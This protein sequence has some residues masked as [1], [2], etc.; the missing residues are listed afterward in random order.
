MGKNGM[1]RAAALAL[2]AVLPLGLCAC[3]SEAASQTATVLNGAGIAPYSLSQG[4]KDVLEAFGMFGRSKLI[5]FCGPEGASG[6]TVHVYR[7]GMDGTWEETGGGSIGLGQGGISQGQSGEAG[8]AGNVSEGAL[9]G[10]FALELGKDYTVSFRINSQ[11]TASYETEPIFLEKEIVGSA[12]GFLEEFREMELDEEAP[13]AVMAYDSGTRM[14]SFSTED[15]FEPSKFEGIDLVQAVTLEFTSGETAG[16]QPAPAAAG[17]TVMREADAGTLEGMALYESSAFFW[18]EEEW[19]LQLWAQEDMVIDGELA[20]DD[21]CRFV[22]RAVQGDGAYTLF[23]DR[24]QLGIPAGEAWMD[25]E[26][27]LHIVIRDVRSAR[28]AVTDFM[29]DGEADAFA[30]EAVMDWNGINYGWHVGA[31]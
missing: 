17:V 12:V 25:T 9:E 14:R 7:L 22:I 1:K 21:N 19:E 28:Y 20:L 29:F 5:A 31:V 18:G 24:V 2:A 15:Y 8:A 6:L 3:G 4:E 27:R 16:E 10:T 23:D 30:G 11:G 13:V 26:N